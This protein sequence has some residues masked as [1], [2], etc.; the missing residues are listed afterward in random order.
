MSATIMD[1]A[2]IENYGYV[3]AGALVTPGK[4]VRSYELWAG[5]PAKFIRKITDSEID[6]IV[7]S[8]KFYVELAKKYVN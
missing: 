1:E 7:N 8:P 6:H 3:A 5:L 2:I 4:I